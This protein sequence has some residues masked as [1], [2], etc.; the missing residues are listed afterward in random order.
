[1]EIIK[2]YGKHPYR[3]GMTFITK[4]K[5]GKRTVTS[6]TASPMTDKNFRQL[7]RN[8]RSLAGSGL[9]P[10]EHKMFKCKGCKKCK[11]A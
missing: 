1:M 10:H 5:S 2:S 4:I 6:Y 9:F 3:D 8:V 11:R 7:K